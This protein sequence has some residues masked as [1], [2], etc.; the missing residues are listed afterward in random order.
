M[1]GR[2]LSRTAVR[3]EL[4]AYQRMATEGLVSSE[5]LRH[6][7]GE[8]R[9]RL[10]SFE[11]IPPLDLGLDVDT[12]MRNVPFLGELDELHWP[13]CADCW[14]RASRSRASGSSGAASAATPCTS[15]PPAR[16][17]CSAGEDVIRLGTGEFFG[18][19]ALILRRPRVADVVAL[20]YCRLLMLRRD[21]FRDF[22]RSHPELM[23]QVRRAAEER[24]RQL[25]VPEERGRRL[26]AC[27]T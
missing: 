12:L 3:L 13:S 24:L 17:R 19:M 26:S 22:L 8:L 18:E 6:L 23:Q 27:F 1:S 20:S 4:E 2:F 5:L 21:A 11:A 7:V 10:E 14:C 9:A 16:S 25:Q 15:S